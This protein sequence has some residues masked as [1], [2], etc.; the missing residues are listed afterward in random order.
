VGCGALAARIK[1]GFALEVV[2]LIDFDLPFFA[3]GS[4]LR[5]AAEEVLPAVTPL[6]VPPPLVPAL[7]VLLMA[8]LEFSAGCSA[9]EAASFAEFFAATF[10]TARASPSDAAALLFESSATAGCVFFSLAV[11][12]VA[13][14]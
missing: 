12:T 13:S 3:L 7:I 11:R 4:E 8:L 10:E 5:A 6:F 9:E 2:A 14:G 1:S